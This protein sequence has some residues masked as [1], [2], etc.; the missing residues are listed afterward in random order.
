[1]SDVDQAF[2]FLKS[3]CEKKFHVFV[4]IYILNQLGNK[5]NCIMVSQIWSL[6]S[7]FIVIF[8]QGQLD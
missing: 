5:T 2:I 1:M 8:G 3:H 4:Y 7:N 6:V